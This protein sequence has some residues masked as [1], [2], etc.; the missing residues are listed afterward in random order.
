MD[1]GSIGPDFPSSGSSWT[2]SSP[3]GGAAS[4]AP[5]YDPQADAPVVYAGELK[6]T[7]PFDRRTRYAFRG[8]GGIGVVVVPGV[9]IEHMAR[10][11]GLQP[12]DVIQNMKSVVGVTYLGLAEYVPKGVRADG[13]RT[14]HRK[15][16]DL[17]GIGRSMVIETV[18]PE[19]P[20]SPYREHGGCI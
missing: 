2:G 9:T 14:G 7:D 5:R 1:N 20:G 19:V 10:G 12:V 16:V 18:S 4:R 8:K 13:R 11:A 15:T 3:I 17:P 6:P